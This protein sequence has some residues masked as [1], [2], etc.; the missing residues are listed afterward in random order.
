MREAKDIKK[1]A[2]DLNSAQILS[3]KVDLASLLH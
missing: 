3:V 1:R 2:K